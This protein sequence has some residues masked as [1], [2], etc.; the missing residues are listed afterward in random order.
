MRSRVI[1]I[2]LALAPACLFPDLSGLGGDASTSDAPADAPIA[3]ASDA[4]DAGPPT[5]DPSKPFSSIKPIA[6][7][8]D[9]DSQFKATLTPDEL[10]IWWGSTQSTDAG[11]V[12]TI[13]HASRSSITAPFANETLEASIGPGDVDPAVSDDGLSLFYS[14][15]GTIGDWDLFETKRATRTDSFGVGFQLPSSMQSTMAETAPFVAFD[16]SLWFLSQRSGANHVWRAGVANGGGFTTPAHMTS[17]DSPTLEQGVVLTHDGLW[18]YVAS[19]RTDLPN[20]GGYDTFL[21]HRSSATTDDFVQ[22]ANVMELNSAQY[23]RANWISWDNCRLY[24]ES[25]RN[26]VGNDDLF[27]A[28][29]TP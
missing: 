16:E 24:F 28:T 21:T 29:R 26:G 6:E 25:E 19:T 1:V 5:C 3:D 2:V 14:K 4:G 8:D 17:L 10:E 9:S 13:W 22:P 15:F 18:A 23:D 12:H 20:A 11:T 7:L 27:V